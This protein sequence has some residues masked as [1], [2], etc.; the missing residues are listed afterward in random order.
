MHKKGTIVK[1][2][3]N[4]KR[5]AHI[6][7]ERKFFGVAALIKL[8]A[9]NRGVEHVIDAD[10]NIGCIGIAWRTK[11]PAGHPFRGYRIDRSW[12]CL[13]PF[14]NFAWGIMLLILEFR[15]VHSTLAILHTPS[16]PP[17]RHAVLS[18]G[19]VDQQALTSDVR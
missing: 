2:S 6:T 10:C 19:R 8:V 17:F 12:S 18:A 4:R 7:A 9:V 13:L 5:E 1:L 11:T 15:S 3:G 16:A 14:P